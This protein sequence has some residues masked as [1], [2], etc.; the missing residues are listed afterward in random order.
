HPVKCILEGDFTEGL[1]L[2]RPCG[3]PKFTVKLLDASENACPVQDLKSVSLSCKTP[4]TFDIELHGVGGATDY[5]PRREGNIT[6]LTYNH[7]SWGLLPTRK[8]MLSATKY[9]TKRIHFEIRVVVDKIPQD[10][11]GDFSIVFKPGEPATLEL[12]SPKPTAAGTPLASVE[13]GSSLPVDLKLGVFD[14]WGNQTKPCD[15]E[16]WE[17]DLQITTAKGGP[18]NLEQPRFPGPMNVNVVSATTTFPTP[19]VEWNKRLLKNG[20]AAEITATLQAGNKDLASRPFK[21][22]ITPTKRPFSVRVLRGNSH[23]NSLETFKAG[24]KI[25]NLNLQLLDQRGHQV[26]DYNTCKNVTCSW[27][28]SKW[29]WQD[30]RDGGLPDLEV[31]HIPSADR[32]PGTVTVMM[33]G[34]DGRELRTTVEYAV[35][36]GPFSRWVAVRGHTNEILENLGVVE[37]TAGSSSKTCLESFAKVVTGFQPVDKYDNKI[38]ISSISER[39]EVGIEGDDQSTI[40]LVQH[41]SGPFR[42]KKLKEGDLFIFPVDFNL[43][44]GP[45]KV[46]LVIRK[47]RTVTASGGLGSPHKASALYL[48]VLLKAGLPG[49]VLIRRELDQDEFSE[50]ITISEPG[51]FEVSAEL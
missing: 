10:L 2:S 4:E 26:T 36:P 18:S 51:G 16:Q 19:V 21:I 35:V 40:Q 38:K 44:G 33:N 28:N 22:T 7:H 34:V 37:M 50:K 1:T 45:G 39:P 11:K 8:G 30:N 14:S 24:E 15:D 29:R 32:W 6:S 23:W 20:G 17:L 5:S 41:A 25:R 42:L 31:I 49:K 48:P 46:S 47:P 12:L 27:N 13:A 9:T 3:V 43:S